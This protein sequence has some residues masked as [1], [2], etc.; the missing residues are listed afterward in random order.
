MHKYYPNNATLYTY[1]YISILEIA[2]LRD[3]IYIQNQDMNG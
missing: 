1:L 2:L 3:Y